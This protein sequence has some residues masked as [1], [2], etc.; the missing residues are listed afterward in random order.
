MAIK[1]IMNAIADRYDNAVSIGGQTIPALEVEA[2]PSDHIIRLLKPNVNASYDAHQDGK[3]RLNGTFTVEAFGK[4]GPVRQYAMADLLE[5][6]ASLL[7]YTGQRLVTGV[8]FHYADSGTAY[9]ADI[10]GA[11][12]SASMPAFDADRDF[13]IAMRVND[14]WQTEASSHPQDPAREGAWYNPALLAQ[15]WVPDGVAHIQLVSI[16]EVPVDEGRYWY[17][18][19]VMTLDG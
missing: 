9:D 16:E 2:K 4:I 12:W 5:H 11:G 14:T 6:V 8:R 10:E 7:N 17:A 3:Y 13:Y 1:R 18:S 15:A 19:L